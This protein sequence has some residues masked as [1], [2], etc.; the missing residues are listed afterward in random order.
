M[1]RTNKVAFLGEG[2]GGRVVMRRGVAMPAGVQV[3]RRCHSR[4]HVVGRVVAHP[5][6]A[7]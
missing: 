5:V 3:K 4:N 7:D 1:W 6:L 2:Y